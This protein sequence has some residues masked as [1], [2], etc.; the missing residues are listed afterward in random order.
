MFIILEGR[1]TLRVAGEMLVIK[2]G[3]MIFIPAGPEYV[4]RPRGYLV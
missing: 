4:W 3:D 2:A 1:G